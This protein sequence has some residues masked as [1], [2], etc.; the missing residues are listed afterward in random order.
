MEKNKINNFILYSFFFIYFF[1]GIY[2]LKD[3]GINI[4]EHTQIYSGFYWLNYIYDFFDI[5]FLKNDLIEKLAKIS[6]DKELPDP[7]IYTYGPI[8]DVPVAFLELLFRGLDNHFFFYL[9]HLLIFFIYFLSSILV[10]KIFKLRFKNFFVCIFGTILF[11]YSPRLYG[12]SFH[13]NKDILFLSL[14]IFSIYYF[15]KFIK[16]NN[17]KYILLFTLFSALSTSTRVIG[18]F[19]PFSVLIFLFFDNIN[20]ENKYKFFIFS[21]III[22]SYLFFLYI[23]WPYLWS[24]PLDNFLNYLFKSANWI[25]SHFILFNKQYLLTY[26]LPD[27]FLY[28]WVA[29]TTPIFNLVLFFLGTFFLLKRFFKRF[30][31]IELFNHNKNSD[32]WRSKNEM[33][34][35]FILLNLFAILSFLLFLHVPFTSGW[36]H[37]YFLNF[38]L[39]YIGTFF[40]HLLFLRFKNVDKLL[41]SIILILIIPNIYKVIVFHPFQSLYFN[42]LLSNEQKKGFLIDREGLSR[43]DSINKILDIEKNNNGVISIANASFLPYYRIRDAISLNTKSKLD[44]VR[45]EYNKADYIYNSFVYEI[46]PKFNKKYQIPDN[47]DLIYTL[48]IEEIVVYELFKKRKY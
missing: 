43:L 42:E 12:D 20:K 15:F 41:A 34:D 28:I 40:L 47:F 6:S 1:L 21:I 44:F 35:N 10:F 25:F 16:K 4:E 13:N 33:L 37:L 14:I 24:A 9:R 17:I 5:D 48:K 26:A 27:S 3:Y 31:S 23:H 36:R 2:S 46:D 22:L 29:I 7:Q 39:I 32:L 8:F 38:F 45:G 11:I 18:L 30:I 19:L